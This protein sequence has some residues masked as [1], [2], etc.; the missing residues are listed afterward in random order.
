MNHSRI[1]DETSISDLSSIKELEK[2][3]GKRA[4]MDQTRITDV[5]CRHIGSN[6]EEYWIILERVSNGMVLNS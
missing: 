1:G 2:R 3:G 6:C 4:A 5:T